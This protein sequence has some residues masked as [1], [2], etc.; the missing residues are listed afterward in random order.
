MKSTKSPCIFDEAR[1][2]AGIES[3]YFKRAVDKPRYAY[4]LLA[5]DPGLESDLLRD[6][7]ENRTVGTTFASDG[8]VVHKEGD[9][10]FWKTVNF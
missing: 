4:Q 1:T 3:R 10:A 7:L 9:I 8:H 5:V 2:F 6:E